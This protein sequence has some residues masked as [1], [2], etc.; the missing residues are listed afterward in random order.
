VESA[1]K[2][3][4]PK[5]RSLIARGFVPPDMTLSAN[6][7][8]RARVTAG[9]SIVLAI[10]AAVAAC[11][12]W[13]EQS[14]SL[15]ILCAAGTLI[16]GSNVALL[17]L[18]GSVTAAAV[19]LCTELLVLLG[20][21]ALL[22]AG[23]VILASPWNLC[24]PLLATYLLGRRTG[25]AFGAVVALQCIALFTLQH[26]EAFQPTWPLDPPT[27]LFS[28]LA[29]LGLIV[30]IGGLFEQAH[31]G[32]TGALAAALEDLRRSD[33]ALRHQTLLYE[34]IL[35]TQSE[36]GDGIA[37]V[38]GNC[39]SFVNGA[40]A[41]LTGYTNDE[42]LGGM[43]ASSL[44][45][46][47][48]L[49][50]VRDLFALDPATSINTTFLTKDGRRTPVECAVQ[51]LQPGSLQRLVVVRDVTER[52]R[53]QSQLMVSDRMTSVGT[54]AAGVAHEIN[55]PLSYILGNVESALMGLPDIHK[56]LTEASVP[57]QDIHLLLSDMDAGLQEAR[58]GAQRV[59]DVVRDLKTFSRADE[60]KH[61]PV[62]L[63]K[64]LELTAHLAWNEIR[65]RARL[66]KN[67]SELLSVQGNESKLGQ[68]FLNLL[69]NAAQAIPEGH[70][71]RNEI[72][73]CAR[74][75]GALVVVEV[76]DT[77]CG[78]P[79]E[80]RSRIFDPFFTTKP[81]GVGT[82]LGLSIVHNI[83]TALGGQISVE[84]AVGVGTTFRV[85]LPASKEALEPA[86]VPLVRTPGR[87]KVLVIDDEPAV[88]SAV[89][90]ALRQHDVTVCNRG[91]EALERLARGERFDVIFCDL[92][93]PEMTGMEVHEQLQS[94]FPD[95]VS[96]MVFLTGGAFTPAAKVFLDRV[97]L[98]WIEKPFETEQLLAQIARL[99]GD[100]P[101]R[102]VV[103]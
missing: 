91:R 90:R 19:A 96:R 80:I 38:D 15:R 56:R 103:S 8:V 12:P 69:V 22:G 51:P 88:A 20:A 94:D 14:D 89:R 73:L 93:M 85:A 63:E 87:A 34:T 35:K 42:L 40:F 3:L 58:S 21:S 78:I 97:T 61:G 52:K 81:V 44:I 11:Q 70:A 39:F 82:G 100:S 98:A 13:L 66:I 36:L 59:R 47:D 5:L 49:S 86:A 9:M 33:Q 43:K 83:V 62:D 71:D 74:R 57:E 72:Q 68:V 18:R 55:N 64:V 84:S 76:S 28:A 92:M 48:E 99:T 26:T 32:A 23:L 67:L 53:L 17:R 60:D 77:G 2:G 7:L 75:E 65:H 45:A 1:A 29:V 10:I 24:V 101:L 79:P 4:E 41:K 37:V 6:D 54:L 31:R 25:A 95:Q 16:F 27:L 102:L 30:L 46:P 50:S